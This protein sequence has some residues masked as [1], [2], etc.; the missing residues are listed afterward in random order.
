M[1]F[2]LLTQNSTPIIGQVAK[3]L[4]WIMNGIFY[5]IDKI[6]IPNVGLAIILFT[7]VVYML[8]MPLTIKQQ[9]FSK[10]SAKM[11]PEL[12][13][14]QAKYKGKTDNDSAMAQN[15][16]I[17][18]VYAKYGV[19]PSGSCVQLLIQ[20][21]ILFALYRVIYAMPAYVTKIGNTFRV[22]AEKIISV[23]NGAFI[24]NSEVESIA[25][26][27]AM[28]GKSLTEGTNVSNGII[29]ILNK[30]YSA[31]L[32]AVAEHYDLNQLTYEGQL[33]LNSDTTRGLIDTYNNFLGMNIAD[34]PMNLIRSGWMVGSWGIVIGAALIPIL[35][36]VTQWINVKL[37]PQAPENKESG[38]SSMAQSMK[39]MNMIMP[40]FSAWLCLSLPAGMGL[41]WVAGSVVRSVQQVLINKHIDKMDFEEIIQK[42]S[43][44]SAKKMEKIKKQ[45]EMMKEYSS[46]NTRNIQSKAATNTADTSSSGTSQSTSSTAKPGSMMAKANMVRDYNERNNNK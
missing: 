11:N 23:D 46:I 22:L 9:K 40:V 31:D 32:A 26:T 34:S 28:Y 30:L 25:N 7:I 43:V 35:S 29:D 14:I 17:Q 27:V 37:M 15:A 42:N 3:L 45:Q 8:M 4:G 24:Q 10:L 6:G 38:Q 33:I 44:K 5:V 1:D 21:P 41:Y 36:A 12:Q 13:A 18:A 16:E 19:S 2:I 20:M 39:T